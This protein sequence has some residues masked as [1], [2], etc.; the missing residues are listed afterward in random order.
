[1]AASYGRSRHRRRSAHPGSGSGAGHPGRRRPRT[2]ANPTDRLRHHR[3][4]PRTAPSARRPAPGAGEAARFPAP[5]PL[6]DDR[7]QRRRPAPSDRPSAPRAAQNGPLPAPQASPRRRPRRPR[8]A[9][10]APSPRPPIVPS[11]LPGV[12]ASGVSWGEAGRR[13][14]IGGWAASEAP[15]GGV[16]PWGV[17]G[18]RR[19]ALPCSCAPRFPRARVCRRTRA[20]VPGPVRSSVAFAVPGHAYPRGWPGIPAHPSYVRVTLRLV[21]GRTGTSPRARGICPD[22]PPTLR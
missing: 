19:A 9:V 6:P 18:W 10:G 13:R 7:P 14:R 17:G 16:G 20:W 2:H 15:W 1:V 3:R 4:L 22:R 12:V 5:S 11:G 8:V 21:P